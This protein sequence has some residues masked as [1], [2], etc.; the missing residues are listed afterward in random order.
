MT[1]EECVGDVM[2]ANDFKT[3]RLVL[4][5][6]NNGE[7]LR[8]FLADLDPDEFL[9]QFG[10]DYD[11]R[12]LEDYDF[13]TSGVICYSIFMP[14]ADVM[15]GY[16]GILPN[17]NDPSA[18][19]LEYYIF[20]KHRGQGY[21]QEAVKAILELFFRGNLSGVRGRSV[22][23]EIVHGNVVSA[24]ILE[25]LGFVQENIGAQ[26]YATGEFDSDGK[27]AFDAVWMISYQLTFPPQAFENVGQTRLA[28]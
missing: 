6:A 22:F 27:E 2:R 19:S 21:C 15:V 4:K 20:K 16:V 7:D 10:R 13:T 26:I 25:K 24:H 1:I 3:R 5:P 9:F 12:L 17:E 23:A 14:D 8:R 28:A 18:G 11:E